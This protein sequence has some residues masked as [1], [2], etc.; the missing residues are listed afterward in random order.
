MIT[1]NEMKVENPFMTTVHMYTPMS[2]GCVALGMI[3]VKSCMA[4]KER[5][6]GLVIM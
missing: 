5:G 1:P 6:W 4:E 3:R 2:S